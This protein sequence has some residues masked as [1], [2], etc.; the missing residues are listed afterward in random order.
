[1]ARDLPWPLQARNQRTRMSRRFLAPLALVLLVTAAP[2]TRAAE[3]SLTLDL[4]A[5][6]VYNDN[7]LEYSDHQL[8]RFD[9]GTNPLRFAVKST[10]DLIFGPGASLTWT[11]DEGK[12]RKHALRAHW[13]GDFHNDNPGADYRSYSARWSESFS[14]GRRFSLGYGRMVD[15]YVR[16]LRDDDSPLLGDARW[17]RAAFDQDAVSASWKQDVQK[18]MSLE[19]GYRFEKRDYV[20]AFKERSSK[21]HQGMVELSWDDL[22][23]RGVVSLSAGYRQSKAEADDGDAVPA[24]DPLLG[25]DDVSYHGFLAGVNG[26]MQFSR[27]GK[28]RFG[29]DAEVDL[30]TRSYDSERSD[31]VD[32]FHLGRNDM[33]IG[34]EAGLRA[35]IR[36]FDARAFFRHETNTADLGTGASPTSDSGSYDKNMF[37]LELSWAVD[38]IKGK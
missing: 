12:G 6:A 15:F 16:Q 33:L 28:W 38:L 31:V 20:P 9:A 4:S 32:P 25:D 30:A 8:T 35:S 21:G 5:S 22:P 23:N 14:K 29:G 24:N 13:D 18:G 2:A 34:F 27:S 37:G 26:R 36:A 11:L 1:M 3:T 17:T 7:F 10:D 19:L